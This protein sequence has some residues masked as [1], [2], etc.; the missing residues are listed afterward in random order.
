MQPYINVS[1][2]D[3]S[4]PTGFPSIDRL[5]RTTRPRSLDVPLY[6][7]VDDLRSW[8]VTRVGVRNH[9][10]T[11][12]DYT[13]ESGNGRFLSATE[14]PSQTYTFAGMNTYVDVFS[15]DPEFNRD[16]SNLYN[17][18]FFRPVPW[19]NFWMDMQLPI[20]SSTGNFTELN[21]GITLMPS[22]SLS[23]TLGHQYI[24]GSPYFQNSNL[25]FSRVYARVTDNWGVSMNHI[26]E[27]DDG[28]MEF[29]S[30]SVTRDLTS[31]VASIGAM[32]RDNRRGQSEIGILFSLTLKDFPGLTIPLDIDPNPSG[33][34]GSQNS[35]R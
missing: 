27:M 17:E 18:I 28:T 32:M 1:Y 14:D 13:K 31:W 35:G 23:L 5:S 2:L 29:Q 3:A 9:L 34:G 12:R 4:H 8:N 10:Q 30:Y 11:R 16:V 24:S 21:Q 7:A 19:V 15:K 25:I 20:M 26:Y 22:S 33:R 6:S